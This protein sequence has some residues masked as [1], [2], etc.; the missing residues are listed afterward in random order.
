M[1]SLHHKPPGPTSFSL[2]QTAIEEAQRAFPD[3]KPKVIH[4][5]ALDPFASGLLIL[6]HGH[7]VKL[8]DHLH[9]VPKTYEATI[10]WGTET[11]NGDPLGKPVATGDASGLTAEAL[12]GVLGQFV[13]WQQQVPP[14][15][16]NKRVGGVRAYQKAHRGEAFELPPAR[17]YLHEARW[18]GHDLPRSSRVHLVARGGYYV[19]SLAREL[20]RAAGCRGHLS[21]LRRVGIG[22]YVDPGPGNEVRVRGVDLLPWLPVRTLTEAE[23]STLRQ[24][25][26]IGTGD[27]A[28]PPLPLPAGFPAAEVAVVRGV[29]Q[30]KLMYLLTPRAGQLE[31]L[32][33]F[34]GGI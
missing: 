25:R 29:L 15:T 22:T 11:D 21:Q 13:G 26:A 14:A 4:A 17:V 18:V 32:T 30:G 10:T 34:P 31:I 28:P 33:P 24:S 27:V 5:G 20:G 3:R 12:E 2:V 9:P 23:V 7:A 19:R 8:F 1:L 6:L 16:S